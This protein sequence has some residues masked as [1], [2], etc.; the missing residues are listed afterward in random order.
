MWP[1]VAN[2]SHPARVSGE[3]R[4]VAKLKIGIL[5][6]INDSISQSW[7][8]RVYEA[9]FRKIY[10]SLTPQAVSVWCRQLGHET[11][12]ATFYGQTDPQDLLP[13]DL[14]VVFFAVDTRSSA[15]AY[16]LAKLYRRRNALTVI[17][18]AHARSFPL[19]CLRFFDL[20]V[21]D[22]DKSLIEKILLDSFER[23]SII[24]TGRM[25]TEFPSVEERKQEVATASFDRRGKPGRMS[26][27][28]VIS[29]VGCPYDCDFCIDWKSTYVML[30]S[31]RL[32]ADLNF[33]ATTWPGI[34]VGYSDP[35]FG[36][37]FDE[38]LDVLE[39]LPKGARN[40][41]VM[42]S[43]LA[44]LRG[45]RLPRLKETNCF[46]V[47][48]GVEGWSDYSNKA[49][50][51]KKVGEE[52]LELLVAHF[53]EI[54]EFV[55]GIQ[56]N[57]LFGTEVD[58]GE[59]PVELTKEFIRRLPF[60]WPTINI[61]V[62]FG[63][64]PLYESQLAAGR[65]LRSMPFSFYYLPYLVHRLKHYHP[66]EYYEKVIEMHEEATTNKML[67][68]RLAATRTIG[69]RTHLAL[70][71]LGMRNDLAALREVLERLRSDSELL[72]FH[73][74]RRE[75]LPSYYRWRYREKLGP[76]AELISDEEMKPVVDPLP[77]VIT[78]PFVQAPVARDST[79]FV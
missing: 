75:E 54:H 4:L 2:R 13:E 15:L 51:G 31:E 44:I 7:R 26:I 5:E 47:A 16:A 64:T 29:S 55:P 21:H 59:E 36:V 48:P 50:V 57:F 74:G 1:P 17:G 37:R 6:I 66:I 38:V 3:R 42:E 79:A 61:P 53:H 73:E 70:R 56:A 10:A 28:N 58:R 18:G 39:T 14:D 76:Y 25:L 20:V 65:V 41:Y 63:G 69:S 78:Q 34:F 62:P 9:Q 35:N 67:I 32:A 52:K 72:A 23:P 22:C 33:I 45:N 77:P 8:N 43:S 30:P 40:P 71:T 49:G 19:D 46:F 11:H 68:R 24:S 60:V 12:Y 27:V